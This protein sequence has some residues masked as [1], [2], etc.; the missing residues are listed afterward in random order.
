MRAKASLRR[1]RL[2]DVDVGGDVHRVVMGG[3]AR[4]PGPTVR[5]SMDYLES[6]AD[7]LRR[8]LISEPFGYD[9]MCVDLVMPACL[10]EAQLG[11][12]IMEVMGYPYYSGSNT[13]AT[14]TAVLEAGLIPMEEGE[15][16]LRLEAPGGLTTVR[17]RNRDGVVE[18]VTAQGSSA[19]IQAQDEVV[20][21]PGL[22]EVRYDLVWSG[23]YYIMVDAASLGHRVV[24]EQ[25]GGMILT[26]ERIVN[27]VQGD[28]RHQHPELGAVGLPRFLHFM[29]PVERRADGRLHTPSATYGHPGVIWRCPTGTG[30]SAR[31]ALMARRGEIDEGELLEAVSPSGNAFTGVITGYPRVGGYEAVDTTITAVPYPVANME[32]TIDIDAPMMRPFQLEHILETPGASIALSPPAPG[33][34]V[35]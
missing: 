29:G 2:V 25:T 13:I 30:T 18:S 35:D 16:T 19:F 11:Y 28:F 14:A 1:L 27:A 7:G 4:C 22:G 17:A 32:M 15:Q 5:D 34:G 3:V 10:P 8:L 24:A 23:G 21:V 20:Q 31:L 33:G 26:A 12:V 6:R 9:S